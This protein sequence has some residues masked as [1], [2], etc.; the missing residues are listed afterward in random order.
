MIFFMIG[1][2]K[3][4]FKQLTLFLCSHRTS[5]C[6]RRD[7]ETVLAI[8]AP[9]ISLAKTATPNNVTAAGQAVGYSFLVTN[10]GNVT[11][12]GV[13]VTDLLPGIGSISCPTD[14]LAPAASTTCTASYV[15]T[16]TDMN[17]GSIVNAAH[18]TGTPPSGPAVTANDAETV[19]AVAAPS[20]QIVK[21]A[22]PT[23]V[24]T[25]GEPIAY[26]FL[27]TNTGNVTLHD[28]A[29][30]DPLPGLTAVN[31]PATILAPGASTLCTAGY[32]TTQADIDAAG[33]HNTATAEG[34][35]PTGPLVTDSD[36]ATVTAPASPG[37]DLE[38]TALPLSVDAA[39]DMVTYS[40]LV[41]NTGNVTLGTVGVSDPLPGLSA[42]ACPVTVL[43]PSAS[44]TCT[45]TYETTQSDIDGGIL[46][47]TATATGTPPAGPAVSATDGATV[48]VTA[49]PSITL[50]KTATPSTLTAAGQTVTYHFLVTNTGNVT[51]HGVGVT[52]ALPLLS[53]V[54][55]PAATLA[56]ST[57]TN[58]TATYTATQADIDAGRIDNTA[59]VNATPPIGPAV[60]D[61]DAA[62]VLATPNPSLT[63]VKSAAPNNVTAA[64]QTIAYSFVVTNTGN[65]TL[66]AVGVTDPLAGLP[67]VICPGSTLEPSASLTCS[68][69]YVATVADIDRGRI[70]N[71]ATATG[72]PPTGPAV[73]TTDSETVT[74]ANTPAIQIVKS[75]APTT[76]T[77]AGQ[78]VAYSFQVINTGNVT[79]HGI[80]VT[81]PLP[82]LGA[83][84]CPASTLAPG[85]S[86]TCTAGYTVTQTDV[87]A[88]AIDNTADV[89]GTPPTGAAVTDTDS[90]TVL[91]SR[92]PAINLVKSASPTTV[93]AAGQ[94][95]ELL[96]PRHQH[97]QRHPHRDRCVRP[98][99]RAHRGD[100]SRHDAR[101]GDVDHLHR[102]LR[103][104]AGR[105]R[106]RR[107]RQHRDG[108]GHASQWAGGHRPGPRDGD[109][110]PYAV[111]DARQDRCTDHDHHRRPD[112][113]LLVRGHQ[114]R[115]RHPHRSR[116]QRRARRADG[117][118]LPGG[119]ARS[120]CLHHLH[121]VEGGHPGRHRQRVDPQHG[122][123][124]RH[125][126]D[127]AAA[128]RDGRCHGHVRRPRPRSHSPRRPH[129]TT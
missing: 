74:A 76:V 11:L 84:G 126:T 67:S 61:T 20:I 107:D 99:A 8:A 93:T 4:Y 25:A 36:S 22:T 66:H 101:A 125:P 58:C 16:V 37:I 1:Y 10:T 33:I 34:F 95:V 23:T 124:H 106:P 119:D 41:T 80:V 88:G 5:Y 54:V 47:N 31:C 27:V 43:A 94:P 92:T 118:Q 65:V 75:A 115:Q 109:H 105:H 3:K 120:R 110:H 19:T 15:V 49:A 128:H 79:L 111:D 127:R 38:K 59:T 12:H 78:T 98:A 62:T 77:A 2:L 70:D 117:R 32:V 6:C 9:S 13:L 112:H 73:T 55:C 104:D 42:I 44:T 60:D 123:R 91:A 45:A 116:S 71:T 21:T 69:S 81:D 51:L 86:I 63:L 90:A 85:A 97:R 28:V 114:H 40:F 100:L 129:R 52:D 68:A 82:G 29:V 26:T 83:I 96:V 89:A 24:A 53:A 121:R 113:R 30:N 102:R 87:D 46:N 14:T 50:D 17:A 122:H 72:S 108:V 48:T 35:P 39:G 57:S 103:R 56:P 18:V 7:A 64:G